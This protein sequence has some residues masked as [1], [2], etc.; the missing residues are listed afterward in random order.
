MQKGGKM[1]TMEITIQ[2]FEVLSLLMSAELSGTKIRDRLA[3]HRP[4]YRPAAFSGLMIRLERDGLLISKI[5]ESSVGKRGIPQ[6]IYKI[7]KRGENAWEQAFAFFCQQVEL[8][9]RLIGG[10]N[11]A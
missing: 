3:E 4:R 2:Q 6:K 1:P 5:D 8:A 11:N 9:G 7:T 10:A